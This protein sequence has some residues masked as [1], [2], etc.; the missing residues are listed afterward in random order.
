MELTRTKERENTF[1]LLFEYNFNRELPLEEIF[2]LAQSSGVE[3]DEWIKTTIS[4]I[5][6]K[7]EE[8]NS[9]IEEYST[10]R[11]L[12]RIAVL[13]KV[14]MQIAIYEILYDKEVPD[15]VSV[16]EAVKIA[17]KYAD[18]HDISFINGLLGNFTR[19]KDKDK[20]E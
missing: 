17:Q 2:E 12:S 1:L 7:E 14:I 10:S 16:S 19:N 8:L 15:N 18:K 13:D 4:D 5:I 6:Q 3:V 20:E 11:K 9:I